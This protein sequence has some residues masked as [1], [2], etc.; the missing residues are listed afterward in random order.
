[1]K[2][3]VSTESSDERLIE[4]DGSNP[5]L[6]E[7]DRLKLAVSHPPENADFEYYVRQQM[8]QTGQRIHDHFKQQ[9]RLKKAAESMPLFSG[10]S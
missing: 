3:P 6:M 4:V 5:I 2:K 1:M 10:D 9:A 7:I 8:A